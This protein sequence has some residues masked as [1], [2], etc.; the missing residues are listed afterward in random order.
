MIAQNEAIDEVI[1]WLKDTTFMEAYSSLRI[2]VQKGKVERIEIVDSYMT[3]RN[4]RDEADN[5]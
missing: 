4:I 3:L 1:R 5:R 2:I